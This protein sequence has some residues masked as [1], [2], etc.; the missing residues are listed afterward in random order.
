MV[1]LPPKS[2]V[3]ERL[4]APSLTYPIGSQ[5]RSGRRWRSEVDVEI[6]D[7]LRERHG[8]VLAVD[9]REAVLEILDVVE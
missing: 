6:P 5:R 3:M 7:R 1:A 4:P 2:V 9:D 8:V